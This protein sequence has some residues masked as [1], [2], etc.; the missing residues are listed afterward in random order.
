MFCLYQNR[1][2]HQK[3]GLYF[4]TFADMLYSNYVDKSR[5]TGPVLGKFRII[6]ENNIRLLCI[7]CGTVF[8]SIDRQ[9]L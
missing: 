1:C 3:T 9:I 7:S 4:L 5:V 6:D 8:A 2:R